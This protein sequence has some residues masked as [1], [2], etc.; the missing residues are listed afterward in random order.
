MET[1]EHHF[2]QVLKAARIRQGLSQQELS[3]RADVH[4]SYISQLERGLKSPSL[5]VILRLAGAIGIKASGLIGEVEKLLE[6]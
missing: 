1:P 3:F 5:G 2:G 4:W 6:A